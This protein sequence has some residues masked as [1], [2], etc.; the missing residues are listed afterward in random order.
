MTYDYLDPAVYKDSQ[1]PSYE[2]WLSLTYHGET[3]KLYFNTDEAYQALPTSAYIPCGSYELTL[4]DATCDILKEKPTFDGASVLTVRKRTLS[5]K[6]EDFAEVESGDTFQKMVSISYL[7]IK[8]QFTLT[9]DVAGRAVGEKDIPYLSAIAENE[10]LDLDYSAA[11]VSMVKRSTGVSIVS[12]VGSSVYYGDAYVP[13]ALWLNKGKAGEM[14]LESETLLYTY[15]S[16]NSTARAQGLPKNA[17]SYTIYCALDSDTYEVA[18]KRITLR[19][20]KRPVAGYFVLV[21]T[22]KVYGDI[23]D[24]GDSKNVQL[25]TLYELDANNKADRTRVITEYNRDM[26]FGS[27]LTSLGGAEAAVAG[28]YDFD[29]LGVKMEN[30]ELKTAIY[31]DQKAHKAVTQFTVEKA[32][33]P[34]A[35]TVSLSVSERTL[36]V[37]ASPLPSGTAEISLS[38]DFSAKKTSN[39][40][41]GSAS[42]SQLTYGARYY[43]RVRSNDDANYNAPS[44]WT[45]KEIAVPY[46]A[47]TLSIVERACD[48]LGVAAEPLED[49]VEGYTLQ[50][51][52]GSSGAWKDGN[53]AEG[54]EADRDYTLYFRAK[55]DYAEGVATPIYARTLRAPVEESEI[56]YRYDRDLET[57]YFGSEI[58]GLEC[59][60]LSSSGESLT[61]WIP[62][63]DLPTLAKDANY[64]LEVRYAATAEKE[65]SGILSIEID[66]HEPAKPFSWKDF[67]S[68]WFLVMVGGGILLAA[69]ILLLVLIKAKRRADKEVLGG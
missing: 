66:T 13:A 50:Y 38:S 33:A 37:S 6:E 12:N 54:L 47:L 42:F 58:E 15:T 26:P 59:R 18:E 64:T 4:A 8:Y 55:N 60:L 41:S 11:S 51:R 69:L 28:K 21:T 40:S 57:L 44:T 65:A 20:A 24:F 61:E 19:I 52:V 23:F 49:A 17:G 3:L 9:A 10:N 14:K 68:D 43:V 36:R 25:T 22:S 31:W 27:S 7:N 63:S 34:A 5:Y 30:Y 29:F 67:L 48:A 2:F 56:S 53:R 16:E 1:C 46:P 32:A 62:Y 39:V 45:E 35:P